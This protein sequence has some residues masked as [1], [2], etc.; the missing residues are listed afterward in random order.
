MSP[1]QH[2]QALP[3]EEKLDDGQQPSSLA[4]TSRWSRTRTALVFSILFL[5]SF[6]IIAAAASSLTRHSNSPN[7]ATAESAFNDDDAA[8][9]KD[10]LN[11]ATDG[12]FLIGVG[13]ADITGQVK[14]ISLYVF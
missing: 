11:R 12:T 10:H 8:W 9:V 7:S 5:L 4:Q 1:S 3:V 13:K 14:P 2:Y 6:T